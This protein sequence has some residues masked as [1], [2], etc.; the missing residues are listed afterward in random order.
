MRRWKAVSG[1]PERSS[2]M[3]RRRSI[4]VWQRCHQDP[5]EL[6]SWDVRAVWPEGGAA[7]VFVSA[8]RAPARPAVHCDPRA[9]PRA[10]PQAG[11]M[12]RYAASWTSPARDI[13]LDRGGA[14]EWSAIEKGMAGLCG[15]R[16]LVD[17][18]SA[19]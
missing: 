5:I 9:A 1:L 13:C 19:R 10:T 14:R 17:L 18:R 8:V 7:P 16:E 6:T 11:A 12:T 15:Q 3:Q 2:P 4:A